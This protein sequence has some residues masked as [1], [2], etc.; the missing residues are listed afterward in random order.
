MLHLVIAYNSVDMIQSL[1]EKIKACGLKD[2]FSDKNMEGLCPIHLAAK[3]QKQTITGMLDRA[4]KHLG[5]TY[6]LL[7]AEGKSVGDICFEHER[8]AREA[9]ELKSREKEMAKQRKL[10]ERLREE[11]EAAKRKEVEVKLA[12]IKKEAKTR[13]IDQEAQE[14]QKAP[15]KLLMFVAILVLF[16]WALLKLGVA[17]GATKRAAAEAK[18]K[19]TIN[20]DFD[21]GL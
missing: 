4:A 1:L 10:E 8:T 11:Q 14:K 16:L 19:E 3:Q 18:P 9:F 7:T 13:Q 21:F 2:L 6:E 15:Y 20:P 17:T 5:V 12:E